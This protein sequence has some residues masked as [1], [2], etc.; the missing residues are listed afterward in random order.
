MFWAT[1]L[2]ALLLICPAW[3]AAATHSTKHPGIQSQGI[4]CQRPAVCQTDAT[5]VRDG[6]CAGQLCTCSSHSRNP[7]SY[8][9]G[10]CWIVVDPAAC[11]LCRLV[12][13]TFGH[14]GCVGPATQ[15]RNA[16]G[17]YSGGSLRWILRST[18]S[19]NQCRP[20]AAQRAAWR[21]HQ[22]LHPHPAQG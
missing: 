16:S 4:N 13:P 8:A 3:F 10:S 11:A 19:V 18:C 1:Y 22:R 9:M 6:Q 14:K 7:R 15:Q 2:G 12:P 17:S 20:G 5:S 21:R